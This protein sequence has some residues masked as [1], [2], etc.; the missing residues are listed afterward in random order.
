MTVSERKLE[1]VRLMKQKK[2]LNY[3]LGWLESSFAYRANDEVD[4]VVIES[5][6]PRLVSM[7]DYTGV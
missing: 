3:T 1:F 2:G 6:T 7:P 5:E 4:L